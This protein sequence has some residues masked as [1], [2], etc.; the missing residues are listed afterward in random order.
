MRKI[1]L[2]LLI[3]AA[4]GDDQDLA[5]QERTRCEQL[6]DHLVDLRLADS[7]STEKDA[8]RE[9]MR[10]ALGSNF[11]DDCARMPARD[12]DCAFAATDVNAAASCSSH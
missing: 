11:L 1:L 2:V 12:I 3:V 8:H 10:N 5:I 7:A 9:A 4:C 6:R